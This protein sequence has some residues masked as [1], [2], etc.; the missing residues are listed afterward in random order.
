[1]AKTAGTTLFMIILCGILG[2]YIGELLGFLM[3]TGF[4]HDIFTKGFPLGF[5]P[6]LVLNL[7][8]VVLTFGFKVILNLFGIVGMIAGLYYSK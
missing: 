2:G 8:V 3:P 1:M 7:R 5:E 4:L 6:P